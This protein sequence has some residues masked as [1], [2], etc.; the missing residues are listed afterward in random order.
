MKYSLSFLATLRK[1]EIIIAGIVVFFVVI[2]LSI[3]FLLPN[4]AKAQ[5]IFSQQ[6]QLEK[7]LVV[8]KTKDR[9]LSSFDYQYY[10]ENMPKISQVLPLFKD[11][12]S[13]F[14][15]FDALQVKTGVVILRT[16]LQ[17]GVISTS[18]A[19]LARN[20][21]N[22]ATALPIALE[23][24][25]NASQLQSFMQSLTDLTGRIL[26]IDEVQLNFKE[27]DLLQARLTSKA[28]FYSPPT[29]IG[30]VASPLSPLNSSLDA[31]LKKIAENP[32]P[33][34][35]EDEVKDIVVGKKNL[36]N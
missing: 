10:K 30:G 25:G 4:F 34:S 12:V 35:E 17:L 3:L 5:M 9:L 22:N 20:A 8:L 29:T 31:L 36:F 6:R 13:L 23:V 26:T 32:L 27:G 28:Y 15:T 33:P 2:G 24:N 7:R 14:N 18:S 21:G 1:Y 19:N 16:E 11:Y